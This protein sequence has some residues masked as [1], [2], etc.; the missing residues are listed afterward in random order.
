M[1][2]DDNVHAWFQTCPERYFDCKSGNITCVHYLEK[3]DCSNHCDDGSDEDPEWAGCIA[4]STVCNNRARESRIQRVESRFPSL[5]S[6]GS[7][8]VTL[9]AVYSRVAMIP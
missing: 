5:S 2:T 4:D 9:A 3:C 6:I 1:D 7:V 8:G